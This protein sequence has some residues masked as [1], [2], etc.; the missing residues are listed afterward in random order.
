MKQ[1]RIRYGA[2]LATA[3]LS[4]L[5]ATKADAQAPPKSESRPVETVEH[6]ADSVGRSLKFNIVLPATYESEPDRRYPV[7][8]MLHGLTSNYTA[9]AMLGVPRVVQEHDL[10]LIVVMAD[11]GNSWYVNWDESEDDSENAWEDYITKDLIEY[12]DT[13]YRTVD[14]REGRAVSGL[15]MGGYGAMM[16]GLRHPDLFCSIG[17]HSEALGYA[18]GVANRLESGRE[19]GRRRDGRDVPNPLIGVP[20]FDSQAERTPHGSI[21]KDAESALDHDP[22]TLVLK[23]PEA[24]R[25]HIYLDCG[26]SD[27]LYDSNIE[28]AKL[29]IEHQIPFTYAQGPGGHTPAYWI[30]EVEQSMIV[31]EMILRRELAHAR[32][33]A[34]SESNDE[35]KAENPGP[36]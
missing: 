16:L 29:M 2:V 33:E 15:S 22:F 26:T 25:P 30:R 36:R 14:S 34:G 21:F 13:H 32:R 18:R 8:Y 31:Q 10:D 4:I 28:F 11:A 17:S 19:G 35:N 12:V 7:I 3:S 5:T 6:Q 9:W 1:F 24:D 20:D 27:G 23:V